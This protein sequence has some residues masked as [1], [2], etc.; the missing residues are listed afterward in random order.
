MT[1]LYSLDVH[2]TPVQMPVGGITLEG[3]LSIPD[4]ARSVIVFAQGHGSCRQNAI[5]T[6]LA[7]EYQHLGFATLVFD[8]FTPAELEADTFDGHVRFQTEMLGTRLIGVTDWLI[9]NTTTHP[10]SIGVMAASTGGAAGIIAVV[11]RP[12]AINALVC[13]AGRPDLAAGLLQYVHTPTLLVVGAND[14][15][16]AAFNGDAAD[17]MPNTCRVNYMPGVGHDFA[18]NGALEQLAVIAGD[19]FTEHLPPNR[20]I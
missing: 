15:V 6:F 7:T 4:G 2:S 17:H 16:I 3:T 20:A 14:R 9:H 11:S 1:R 10:M 18:E 13:R 19:W 12:E 8:L 5:D